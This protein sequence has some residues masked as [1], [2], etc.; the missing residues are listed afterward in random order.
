[1]TT[2]YIN[3]RNQL[4]FSN[5]NNLNRK[6]IKNKAPLRIRNNSPTFLTQT[7]IT[8]INP[9]IKNFETK[10]NNNII[11]NNNKFQYNSKK[12]NT[13]NYKK[14]RRKINCNIK[15]IQENQKNNRRNLPTQELTDTTFD[16]KYELSKILAKIREKKQEGAILRRNSNISCL[17]KLSEKIRINRNKILLKQKCNNDEIFN[18]IK[19]DHSFSGIKKNSLFF[20][21][22]QNSKNKI[23]KIKKYLSRNKS[24]NYLNYEENTLEKLSKMKTELKSIKFIR[25]IKI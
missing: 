3:K 20:N 16:K 2:F 13:I 1:M 24:R 4:L 11:K 19:G 9:T 17:K 23:E 15:L 7:N 25:K 6:L 22:N 14:I 8:Q 18:Y 12:L 10:N 5:I 21:E